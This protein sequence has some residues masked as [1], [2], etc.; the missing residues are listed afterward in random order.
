M[1]RM[2]L[3]LSKILES[4]LE[5]K[6]YILFDLHFCVLSL[7][8]SLSLRSILKS[9]QIHISVTKKPPPDDDKTCTLNVCETDSCGM[10]MRLN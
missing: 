10:R 8:L 9:E 4:E 6:E 1:E 7:S 3:L 5:R 2:N